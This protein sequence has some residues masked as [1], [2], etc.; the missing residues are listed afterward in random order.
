M[1]SFSWPGNAALQAPTAGGTAAFPPPD[2][3]TIP[4]RAA[5]GRSRPLRSLNQLPQLTP[6][7]NQPQVHRFFQTNTQTY[8]AGGLWGFRLGHARVVVA[9]SS[10]TVQAVVSRGNDLPKAFV[11]YDSVEEVSK[12]GQRVG[13]G[14][15]WGSAACGAVL[16][17]SRCGPRT[18][19][20]AMTRLDLAP[21]LPPLQLFSPVGER[22]M[23]NTHE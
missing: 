17:G 5:P 6:Q 8:G 21:L 20:I 4:C 19:G 16:M 9:C 13:C 14:R 12:G 11:V 3:P 15:A 7:V 1:G 23:F 10:E 2:R 22:S 18:A